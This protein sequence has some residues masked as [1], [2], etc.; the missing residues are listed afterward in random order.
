MR[1]RLTTLLTALA[2]SVALGAVGAPAAQADVPCVIDGFTPRSV[3]VGLAPRRQDVRRE[4]VRLLPGVL[5]SRV[6][7][8]LRLQGRGAADD[9]SAVQ[10]RGRRPRRGRR[11]LERLLHRGIRDLPASF[12]LLRRTTWQDKSVDASPEPARRGSPITVTGRL[13]IVD[14]T[15]DRYVPY[16]GRSMALEFRDGDRLLRP[17]QDGHDGRE[18]LCPHDGAGRC[19]GYLAAALR[20]RPGRRSGGDGR[21]CRPGGPLTLCLTADAQSRPRPWRS[22][23]IPSAAPS[24]PSASWNR[25]STCCSRARFSRV[26]PLALRTAPISCETASRRWTSSMIAASQ[27]SIS[28]RSV[29]IRSTSEPVTALVA[30]VVHGV[31][32]GGREPVLPRKT[33]NAPGLFG[34]GASGAAV[35]S[36]RRRR[37]DPGGRSK[38]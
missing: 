2:L 5:E 24:G 32:F 4:H 23:I 20:R 16:A 28:S 14:W 33:K 10:R 11:R 26:P 25:A 15:N 9:R 36:L 6:R 21:R 3:V 18:G 27:A 38:S 31:S 12:S 13:L 34:P 1:S 29:P 17:R 35:L 7:P 22:S 8:V 37:P 19:I 30:V